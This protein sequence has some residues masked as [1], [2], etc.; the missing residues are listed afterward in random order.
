MGAL[1]W[2]RADG[3]GYRFQ[4]AAASFA[5]VGLM[6]LFVGTSFLVV[7]TADVEIESRLD[8]V[9]TS[10]QI[11]LVESILDSVRRSEA[12]QRGFLLTSG[13]AYLQDYEAGVRAVGTD[14][15]TFRSYPDGD[16]QADALGALVSQKLAELATSMDLAR[17]DKRDDALA[18]LKSGRGLL[19]MARIETESAKL[20]RAL[21]AHP[22]KRWAAHN[23]TLRISQNT[24]LF[25]YGIAFVMIGLGIGVIRA[26]IRRRSSIESELRKRTSEIR[27]R[28]VQ[29][30]A[31][32]QELEGFAYAA[33]HDLKAPLRAVRNTATW[34]EEDLAEHLTGE[35][36]EHF[37]VLQARV[38]RMEKLLEDLLEYARIGRAADNRYAEI[39]SGDLL[40]E[41]VLALVPLQGFTVEVSPAFSN[42]QVSRMPLQQILMNLVGNAIKH[43]H[44]KTGEI[45]VT[46]RD[47]GDYHVFAVNDDGPGIGA[48]FHARI[49]EMFR[50]LRPRDH[51]EGSG[52][53]L[54]MV[55]K[56]IE[57]CGGAL[58]LESAEGQGSTFRFSLPKRQQEGEKKSSEAATRLSASG[59]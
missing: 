54:A 4:T 39:I 33:S 45:V 2:M 5:L 42:I 21:E 49:F 35:T 8:L 14:L 37:R 9:S 58:Q 11:S 15:Q 47:D 31:A 55:R 26:E 1:C 43:H 24:V 29:L 32:N 50:T 10:R 28:T 34:L 13:E 25:S 19:L 48:Q 52:I 30:E 46:V 22:A 6:L 16:H 56:H 23:E 18:I 17:A 40:M 20:I 38:K 53:G 7:T 57:V 44:K 12:G 41:D 3:P 27:E 51:V 36:R 59:I